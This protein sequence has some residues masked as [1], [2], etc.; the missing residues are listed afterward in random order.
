LARIWAHALLPQGKKPK[1]LNIEIFP[2]QDVPATT[3]NCVKAP[4]AR[5]AKLNG[6]RVWFEAPPKTIKD[7]LIW[8]GQQ[9]LNDGTKI[10]QLAEKLDQLN[11]ARNR[12]ASLSTPKPVIH[13]GIGLLE[14]MREVG[15]GMHQTGEW[16]VTRCPSCALRGGDTGHSHLRMKESGAL[17]CFAGCAPADIRRAFLGGSRP[18]PHQLRKN[19]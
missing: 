16:F 18:E 6:E 10:C 9:P 8:L 13:K 2:K 7:Q 12:F 14:L 3:G 17:M 15:I 4:L 19:T 5:H 11:Q 1:E